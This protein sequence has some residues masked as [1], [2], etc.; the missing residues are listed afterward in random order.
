MRGCLRKIARKLVGGC[1]GRIIVFIMSSLFWM[2][3]VS[4]IAEWRWGDRQTKHVTF[5]Q[6][7]HPTL[8]TRHVLDGEKHVGEVLVDMKKAM[9]ERVKV[10]EDACK[11][12]G[13]HTHGSEP[14]QQVNPWEYFIN[15]K[16]SLVWCNVFKSASTSWM[17]IFNV[18]SGYTPR[19]LKK[20]KKVP[21]TLA[22]ERYPRPSVNQL[23]QVLSLPNVTSVII[24]RNPFERLV[25]A[26]KDK[27]FGALPGT[28]HD[29][30]RR[31]ITQTYRNVNVPKGR[32]LQTSFIPSFKE[33]VQ[34]IVDENSAQNTPEMHWAPVYSFCNPCQVNLNSIAKFETLSED[35]TFLLRKIK[36]AENLT[37]EKKNSAKDGKSSHDVTRMYLKELDKNLYT[38]LVQLYEI[39]FD[40]FGYDVPEY[41]KL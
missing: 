9:E 36:G 17:Y 23:K 25:S 1:L 41:E 38:R 20:T 8:D 12:H 26:Y 37:V 11:K 27:I 30:M 5:V 32:K 24:G 29:K 14:L 35:T 2:W 31:K 28:F 10:M 33:F 39:D 7:I 18:L 4:I 22:R 16:H 13:L 19:F 15:Q 6:K 34:Y 3:T 40:I 21:L